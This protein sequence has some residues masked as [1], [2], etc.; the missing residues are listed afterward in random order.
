VFAWVP[1]RSAFGGTV[2]D[3]GAVVVTGPTVLAE[4]GAIA[5]GATP[6]CW[7][8]IA[9]GMRTLGMGLEPPRCAIQTLVSSPSSIP[10]MSSLFILLTSLWFRIFAPPCRWTTCETRVFYQQLKG[11]DAMPLPYLC[12]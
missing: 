4:P 8:S 2:A 7:F 11:M 6:P 5:L 12:H 3:G 10:Q 9:L 1:M